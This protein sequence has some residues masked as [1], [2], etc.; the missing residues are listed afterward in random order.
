MKIAVLLDEQFPHGM[1]AA[2][3]CLLYTKG[4]VG[5]GNDVE[6]LIPRATERFYKIRNSE[7]KGI[8]DGVKFRYA[9]ESVIRKSFIGRRIQNSISLYKSL[10]FLIRFNPDIILIGANNFKYIML[11]K[12]CSILVNAK[13]VREK[14]EVPFYKTEKLSG[15]QKI[16]IKAEFSLFHGLIVISGAL[17]DFFLNDLKLKLKIVVVPILIDSAGGTAK[18]NGFLAAKQNLV[19]TGSLLDHKDG[20]TTIIK[21]FGRVLEN[22]PD[23]RLI[24]T[25]DLEASVNKEEILSL[26]GESGFQE[27]IELP[28]YVSKEKLNELTSEATALLLAKPDNRQNRYNMATKVGE[29]LLTG[30]P[31]VISSVDPVCKYLNHRENAFITEPDHVQIAEE[32]QFILNNSEKSD[33]IGSAGKESVVKLFDYRIHALRIDNFFKNL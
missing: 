13:L 14:S 32:I 11:G 24:M 25:G 31:V 2:N 30:R 17:K 28:G 33:A 6:V 4:L 16:K 20:V 29:Y 10:V 21:A 12:V 18:Q 1:A 5:L 15:F 8:Y 9:Y 19:Y 27:K 22:H 23:V 7:I 3:R 26:I